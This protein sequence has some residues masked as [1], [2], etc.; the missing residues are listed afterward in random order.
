MPRCPVVGAVSHGNQA[1]RD[2]R[3]W[4]ESGRWGGGVGR[5]GGPSKQGAHYVS[6]KGCSRISGS[7]ISIGVTEQGQ[8]THRLPI[9]VSGVF[10]EG[11]AGEGS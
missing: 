8:S 10:R 7:T 1:Q 3:R 4:V 6:M 2:G 5:I 9:E 11:G